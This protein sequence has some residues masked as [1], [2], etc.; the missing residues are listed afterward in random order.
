MLKLIVAVDGSENAQRAVRYAIRLARDNGPVAI[1]LVTVR[2]EQLYAAA[3]IAG[4][5]TY[6]RLAKL[7]QEHAEKVLAQNGRLL[8]EADVPYTQEVLSGY[9]AQAIARCAEGR[10]CDGIVLGH[11]GMSAIGNLV[12]GSVATKVAHFATRPVTL[13]K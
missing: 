13:V 4:F 3:E 2:E 8:Q 5:L 1:H 10:D 11:R 7:Q 12:M 6:E 9:V